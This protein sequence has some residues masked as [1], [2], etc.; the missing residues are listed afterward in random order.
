MRVEG[1]SCP[2]IVLVLCCALSR[3]DIRFGVTE[4]QKNLADPL[5]EMQSLKVAYN[6][7]QG[8]LKVLE[9]A[10]LDM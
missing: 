4:R 6:E 1:K 7:A 8:E 5:R 10:A 3:F 9:A 2:S